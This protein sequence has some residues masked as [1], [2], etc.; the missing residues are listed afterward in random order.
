MFAETILRFGTFSDS[1]GT[2]DS[3][4]VLSEIDEWEQ[5]DD[6]LEDEV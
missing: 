5:L 6:G 2:T 1:F 3:V 4:T